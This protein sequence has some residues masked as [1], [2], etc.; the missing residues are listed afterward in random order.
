MLKSFHFMNTLALSSVFFFKIMI[1]FN[2]VSAEIKTK[3]D[4]ALL[5][6]ILTLKEL[7]IAQ[8]S[9]YNEWTLGIRFLS[10]AAIGQ[11]SIAL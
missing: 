4:D 3:S 2:N 8:L 1:I 5:E 10:F 11:P 7:R 6:M 9:S